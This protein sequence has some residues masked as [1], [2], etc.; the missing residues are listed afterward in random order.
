MVPYSGRG[1]SPYLNAHNTLYPLPFILKVTQQNEDG[2]WDND[3]EDWTRVPSPSLLQPQHI[4]SDMQDDPT[5]VYCD[6]ALQG[7]W[8]YFA[9]PG[10]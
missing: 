10:P 5:I 9:I 8:S 1:D 6:R 3:D 7:R 4:L 2:S